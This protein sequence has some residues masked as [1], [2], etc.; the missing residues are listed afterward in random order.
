[1]WPAQC[2]CWNSRNAW[3]KSNRNSTRDLPRGNSALPSLRRSPARRTSSSV[4]WSRPSRGPAIGCPTNNRSHRS[5]LQ[6]CFARVGEQLDA[7]KCCRVVAKFKG[8]AVFN[9]CLLKTA[10]QPQ[11]IGAM[12]TDHR[13]GG[14]P[15]RRP[16]K[17]RVGFSKS[18]EG[19][20]RVAHADDQP[21]LIRIDD[22]S[23]LEGV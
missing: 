7:V 15:M 3:K 17:N 21:F 11:V 16:V 8:L 18:I 6:R 20:E 10:R 9:F 12:E 14:I 19:I 23:V 2:R 4:S 5:V 22:Q 13:R 1:M